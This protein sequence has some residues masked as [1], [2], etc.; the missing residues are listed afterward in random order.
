[1]TRE[2]VEECTLIWALHTSMKIASLFDIFMRNFCFGLNL[3]KCIFDTQFQMSFAR[4]IVLLCKLQVFIHAISKITNVIALC[5]QE[6]WTC[7]Y[8]LRVKTIASPVSLI[9]LLHTS[10]ETSGIVMFKQAICDDDNRDTLLIIIVY[11]S[12]IK[13]SLPD[14]LHSK[15]DCNFVCKPSPSTQAAAAQRQRYASTCAQKRDWHAAGA[16]R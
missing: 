16:P 9:S 3:N 1:M 5:K 4:I 10:Y 7:L 13:I 11:L 15:S 2:F 12:L 6:N 14:V 8:L